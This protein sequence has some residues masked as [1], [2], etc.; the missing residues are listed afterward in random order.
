MQPITF[1]TGNAGKF[2]EAQAILPELV[3]LD[4]D[5]SE[6]QSLHPREVIVAKLDEARKRGVAGA[7]V[8]EDTSLY[9]D[10]LGGLPGPLIKW[11]LNRLKAEGIA[12]LVEKLGKG[13]TAEARCIVGYLA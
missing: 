13:N 5:L 7:I 6:I 8:V 1:L 4:V 3:Q 10:A 9:I 11:F 2:K 12:E